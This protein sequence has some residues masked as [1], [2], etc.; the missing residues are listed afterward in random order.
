MEVGFLLFF[1]VRIKY[2]KQNSSLDEYLPM[3]EWADVKG[4]ESLTCSTENFHTLG[5]QLILQYFSGIPRGL[6]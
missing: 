6:L 3:E 5:S 4:R 1:F 2:S